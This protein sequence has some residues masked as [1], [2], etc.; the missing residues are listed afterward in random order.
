MEEGWAVWQ[1]EGLGSNLSK[2]A[3]QMLEGILDAGIV[4]WIGFFTQTCL[5]LSW[6]Y[7][8]SFYELDGLPFT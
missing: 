3:S 7:F 8:L 2:S 5:E 1:E 6:S 4:F